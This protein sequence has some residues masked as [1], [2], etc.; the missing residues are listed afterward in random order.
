[1][2]FKDFPFLSNFHPCTI[3]YNGLNF[4]SVENAYQA[5]KC[6]ERAIEFVNITANKAKCLGKKVQVRPDWDDV[7]L[8]IMWDLVHQKFED[9]EL[10]RQLKLID[11]PIV[12]HNWWHDNYWGVCTCNECRNKESHNWLGRILEDIKENN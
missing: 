12:E 10:L 9:K 11:E 7:K 1:M 5:Q 3:V 8:K 2:F 6:P 4:P